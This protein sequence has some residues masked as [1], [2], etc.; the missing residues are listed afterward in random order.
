MHLYIFQ[1]QKCEMGPC[2][3]HGENAYYGNDQM[4]V[5][6][7][8]PTSCPYGCME[9]TWKLRRANAPMYGRT[10]QQIHDIIDEH[11]DEI[12]LQ[13]KALLYSCKLMCR[14]RRK[15]DTLQRLLGALEG[16][17]EENRYV[18]DPDNSVD[19]IYNSYK[20][21]DLAVGCFAVGVEVGL[22]MAEA[23]HL[24]VQVIEVNE[25]EW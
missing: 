23:C 14:D 5:T 25:E 15:H 21:K 4:G 9:P 24:G 13:V 20:K 18:Y 11:Y 10:V 7:E 17:A 8:P 1:C 2:R 19:K 6:P 3:V 22:M 12:N 16:F